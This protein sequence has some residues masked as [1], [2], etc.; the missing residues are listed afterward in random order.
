MAKVEKELL[1]KIVAKVEEANGVA[2]SMKGKSSQEVMQ[3]LITILP[4]VIKEVE[5]IGGELDSANKKALA[6]EAALKYANCKFLPDAI[7]R[8]F[9]SLA[10]D[11]VIGL[12]NKWFGNEW[13]AKLTGF[14]KKAW[15]FIKK[16][17]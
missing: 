14:I 10:I 7:E 17:F 15:E 13:A 12:L 2:K 6:I 1:A 5:L 9:L 8:Q 3:Y 16:F 4:D 11:F